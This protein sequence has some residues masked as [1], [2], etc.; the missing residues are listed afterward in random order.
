M[1]LAHDRIAYEG[2]GAGP[3][4]VLI[5]GLGH[6]RQG[7]D[8]VLCLLTPHREVYTLDLPGHGESP[9]LRAVGGGS[10]IAD[11]ATAIGELFGELGLDRPHLA[12]NSLGGALALVLAA[13]GRGASVTA[14]SPAGFSAHRYE[15]TYAHVVFTAARLGS[16]AIMPAVP[17]LSRSAAGRRLLYGVMVTRP[18]RI[19]PEQTRGDVT[20][21][22][23][24]GEAMRTAFASPEAFTT[25]VD[26]PVTIAW[27]TRDRILP[28]SNAQVARERFPNARFV[29]LPGCG[30][31]PMTDDP[32]LVARVILEG[33][34]Q[35]TPRK[36]LS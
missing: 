20:N 15:H 21:F 7:W 8:A 35:T 3:P 10:M 1:S 22:A 34:E 5:H 27:G 9:P 19:S 25:H 12:G 6:R 28:P 24:S 16:L 13:H 4:L 2:R 31:V 29:D 33:S 14:L 11:M 26:V 17:A 18:D 23:H 32:E 36:V 30:H